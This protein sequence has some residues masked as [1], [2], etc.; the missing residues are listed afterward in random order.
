MRASIAAVSDELSVTDFSNLGRL[1]EGPHSGALLSPPPQD[2][3]EREARREA[4]VEFGLLP[5]SVRDR[6]P[7]EQDAAIVQG[8]WRR[9]LAEAPLFGGDLP[10]DARASPPPG[11]A[12]R[13]KRMIELR[14]DLD[15]PRALLREQLPPAHEWT[16]KVIEVAARILF[17]QRATPVD[18]LAVTFGKASVDLRDLFLEDQ[19]ERRELKLRMS[20][21]RVAEAAEAAFA[22]NDQLDRRLL[23]R[24]L[25]AEFRRVCEE[26]GREYDDT[27]LRRALDL[28]A[29]KHPKALV[30]AFREAQGRFLQV[31]PIDPLPAL[32]VDEDAPLTPAR[33]SAWG[34][35]PPGMNGEERSFAELLDAD[36]SGRVRWWMKLQEG[37]KWAATLI[38]PS[39]RHFFPDFAVGIEGRRT[40][41][42]VALVEVKDNG[43][44]GRLHADDNLIKIRAEHREY[45]GVAWA[46][47]E[48]GTWVSA[49]LEPGIDRIRLGDRFD[50]ERLA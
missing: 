34:V 42:H 14:T 40:P 48:D 2:E 6:P 24:G 12:P 27:A 23:K 41:D 47:R 16:D 25:L 38:L 22:F 11:A 18:H 43:G 35:F 10:E 33:L 4:L 13:G 32:P 30:E 45:R 44:S 17:R 50:V 31:G 1:S 9:R 39:G 3:G 36:A 8:E 7:A 19:P 46:V 21:A 28:F 15:L 20:S 29:L 5:A 49:R 26:Q 37:T